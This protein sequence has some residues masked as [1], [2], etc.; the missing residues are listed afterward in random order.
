M[1]YYNWQKPSKLDYVKFRV[2]SP[3]LEALKRHLT[4]RWGGTN[5]G[6]FV[7][8]PIRGGTVPSTHSFGAALDWRYDTRE[9][10]KEAIDWIVLNHEALGVQMIGDYIGSCIWTVGNGWK[11]QE[12]NKHG[13]GQGWAKWLHI[14]T[15]RESWGDKRKVSDRADKSGVYGSWVL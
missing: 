14:E 11:K 4:K 7:K 1:K 6:I 3:N 9:E 2:A 15:S 8:R 13:M 12:P 5:L 10:G